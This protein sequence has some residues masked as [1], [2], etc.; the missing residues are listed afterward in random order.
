V[1]R[2]GKDRGSRAGLDDAPEVHDRDVA[3]DVA[4][5]REVVR[6]EQDR[7]AQLPLQ[8]PDQVEHR[9]LDRD[10]ERRGDL[11]G[12]EDA[13]S[14][15]EGARERDAL[16]LPAGEARGV[17]ARTS[18]VEVDELEQPPRLR[19]AFRAVAA[20]RTIGASNLPSS[21]EA[22]LAGR[23]CHHSGSPPLPRL[24]VGWRILASARIAHWTGVGGH[25][26]HGSA[27]RP[28]HPVVSVGFKQS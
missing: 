10:I 12:D 1:L 28:E 8:L 21:L 20:T 7:E 26:A 19:L 3:R 17:G 15:G 13:R 27:D 18:R 16:P 5:H 9:G 22:D 14:S 4:H 23:G 24:P 11:V 6:D 25:M 2:V